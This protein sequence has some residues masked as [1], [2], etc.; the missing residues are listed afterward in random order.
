MAKGG[1]RPGAG[2]PKGSTN[3]MTRAMRE[4]AAASGKLPHEILLDV[5]RGKAMPGRKEKPSYEQQ[6]DAAKAAAPYYAP[7]LLGA[8]VKT[9]GGQGNPW[10]EIIALT[11]GLPRGLPSEVSKSLRGR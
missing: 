9:P 10:D 3:R 7:R 8:V 2:R 11:R 6:L 5:A 4:A 1:K